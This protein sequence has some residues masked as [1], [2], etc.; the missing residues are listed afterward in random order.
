MIEYY[1]DSDNMF[2]VDN[3]GYEHDIELF[4]EQRDAELEQVNNNYG[5]LQ[6]INDVDFDMRN[7][8][9]MNLDMADLNLYDKNFNIYKHVQS[10][11]NRYYV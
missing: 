4:K 8:M 9:L 10:Y 1:N 3:S 6:Y 5:L 2:Y 11:G 7:I